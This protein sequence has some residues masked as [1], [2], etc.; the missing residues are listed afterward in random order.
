MSEDSIQE[1]LKY[2]QNCLKRFEELESSTTDQ[3]KDEVDFLRK[4]VL[5][6]KP[7]IIDSHES[8]RIARQNFPRYMLQAI[9]CL[10]E[11]NPVCLSK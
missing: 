8:L 7:E 3:L 4:A 2:A 11:L 9:C 1:R 10:A 6:S 5:S